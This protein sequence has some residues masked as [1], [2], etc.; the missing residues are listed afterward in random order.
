MTHMFNV[1]L[2]RLP[3]EYAGYPIDADFRTGIQIA[4]CMSDSDLTKNEKLYTA[5]DLLFPEGYPSDISVASEGLKWF[6]SGWI[7]DN[8]TKKSGDSVP[9]MDYDMDQWRIYAAFLEK[10]QINLNTDTLHFWEFMGLLN[11]LED[12]SFINVIQ[13]RQ[14]KIDPKMGQDYKKAIQEQKERYE[15]KREEVMTAEE[16]E[17]QET[18]MMWHKQRKK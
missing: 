3:D 17:E 16:T 6:M 5:L 1:L 18:F 11:A 9:V 2:D 7:T 12:C 10:Y 8:K 13:L 14:Q 4:M 15:I